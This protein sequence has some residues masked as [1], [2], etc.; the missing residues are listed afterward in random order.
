MFEAHAIS[1]DHER[2]IATGWQHGRLSE[3]GRALATE[4]GQRRRGSVDVVFS[5][6]LRR[7][8]ETAEIAFGG[9]DVPVL[10]DWRLRECDY[11]ERNGAPRDELE[12]TRRA[13]LDAPYPGGESWREAAARVSR[14]IEDVPARW[15][16]RRVLI[17]GHRA[18]HFG[19][20]HHLNG[21]PLEQLIDA[22]FAWQPGWDY[23][24]R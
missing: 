13:H 17:I 18:T 2:G 3:K 10:H 20:E 7:A 22:P 21:V 1:E 6:D 5:S 15:R 14:F 8:V 24:L 19:L 4:L 9:S 12:R 11:G 16:S 23:T